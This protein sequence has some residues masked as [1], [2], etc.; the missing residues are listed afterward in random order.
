[1]GQL[2]V[3]GR[4]AFREGFHLVQKL[5]IP[6]GE[7]FNSIDKARDDFRTGRHERGER[8]G[9][10]KGRVSVLLNKLAERRQTDRSQI[11]QKGESDP[12]VS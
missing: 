4:D 7:F 1:M 10:G 6:K 11:R 2:L 12:M 3:Q 9:E 8:K 5:L